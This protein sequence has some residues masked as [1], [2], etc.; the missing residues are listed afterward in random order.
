[1]ILKGYTKDLIVVKNIENPL[2]DEA[3][4]ILKK[5]ARGEAG[6][7]DIVKEANR[8]IGGFD[9]REK[10]KAPLGGALCF[11]LGALTSGLVISLLF[12]VAMLL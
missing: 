4:L 6:E 2:I 12:A 11:L 3:Y 5:E 8:L 9:I 1:M 10:K 7:D